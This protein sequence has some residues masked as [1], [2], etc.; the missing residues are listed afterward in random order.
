MYKMVAGFLFCDLFLGNLII[1]QL[2]RVLFFSELQ[3][4]ELRQ[5]CVDLSTSAEG[6]ITT[7]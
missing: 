1:T 4:Y 2:K 5:R 3:F 6:E 7:E